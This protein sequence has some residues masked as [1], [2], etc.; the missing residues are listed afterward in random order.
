MTILLDTHSHK[1]I[2]LSLALPCR[3]ENFAGKRANVNAA[4][5]AWLAVGSSVGARRAEKAV[6]VSQKRAIMRHGMSAFLI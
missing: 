5:G 4:L 3:N 1:D 6:G 2:S